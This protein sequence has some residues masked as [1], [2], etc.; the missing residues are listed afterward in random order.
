[1]LHYFTKDERYKQFA[2]LD[3]TL[4]FV[5]DENKR[6]Q[7]DKN[8][9]SDKNEREERRYCFC[10]TQ[11]WVFLEEADVI[12]FNLKILKNRPQINF[13]QNKTKR[14]IHYCQGQGSSFGGGK[15]PTNYLLT[16]RNKKYFQNRALVV[17]KKSLRNKRICDRSNINLK[18]VY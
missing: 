17:N 9:K 2:Y 18:I 5:R 15:C 12:F 10:R 7:C 3:K 13:S 4:R 1:M 16:G 14:A 11:R 6:T 8:V